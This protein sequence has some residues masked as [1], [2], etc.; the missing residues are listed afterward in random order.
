M[1]LY[2]VQL[3]QFQL[4]PACACLLPLF[5]LHGRVCLTYNL[6]LAGAPAPK[7]PTLQPDLLTHMGQLCEQWE[8][9]AQGP[10]FLVYMLE[11]RYCH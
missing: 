1:S 11:H 9:D 7:T 5:V 3:E 4:V 8:A 10:P 2:P 6:L